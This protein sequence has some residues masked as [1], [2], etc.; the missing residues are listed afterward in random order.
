MPPIQIRAELCARLNS[1]PQAARKIPAGS[2]PARRRLVSAIT[3]SMPK[4]F[5]EMA[6]KTSAAGRL[7]VAAVGP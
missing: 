7:P 6:K 5:A 4:P 3:S 2:S 1:I